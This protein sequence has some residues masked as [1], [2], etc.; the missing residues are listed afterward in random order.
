MS[1][2]KNS[3]KEVKLQKQKQKVLMKAIRFSQSE[4]P[5]FDIWNKEFVKEIK[6]LL[7]IKLSQKSTLEK[8]IEKEIPNLDKI[9]ELKAY[10][11]ELWI[12]HRHLIRFEMS[13][14]SI[15]KLESEI[16]IVFDEINMLKGI[17]K[18]K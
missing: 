2:I 18:Y 6:N 12:K 13:Q 17:S 11:K 15:N 5:L 14:D 7:R 8:I 1:N 3:E 9:N 10:K 4:K 16:S